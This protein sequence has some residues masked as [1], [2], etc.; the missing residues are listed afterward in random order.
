[1]K[2]LSAF[3]ISEE[4]LMSTWIDGEAEGEY[5]GFMKGMKKGRTEG[6]AEGREQGRVEGREEGLMTGA[7]IQV[8]STVQSMYK[9]G[10]SVESIAEILGM[11][12]S[13]VEAILKKV[14]EITN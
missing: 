9:H 7:R 8:E 3:G 1:M 14:G 2:K 13:E 4:T 11:E 6:R 12:P 10:M 5:K